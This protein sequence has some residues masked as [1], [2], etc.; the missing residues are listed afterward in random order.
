MGILTRARDGILYDL[1]EWFVRLGKKAGVDRR[2]VE[3]QLN[4]LDTETKRETMKKA[5]GRIV[6][7]LVSPGDIIKRNNDEGKMM[8]AIMES[9]A[10]IEQ[11][12]PLDIEKCEQLIEQC[13]QVQVKHYLTAE[14]RKR[15]LDFA[16]II[17]FR[18]KRL[19]EK[20]KADELRRKE[21]EQKKKHAEDDK[22]L[23]ALES[24]LREQKK[25]IE[26]LR[27][28]LDDSRPEKKS[29][30]ARSTTR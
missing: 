5:D 20:A 22:I 13:G 29:R 9:S 6:T 12:G 1:R 23:S 18:L 28:L 25:E 8:R 30:K 21:D 3:L 17:K 19:D 4:K 16:E 7:D 14:Q 27:G 11:R 26:R 2:T 10:E 24:K 15:F